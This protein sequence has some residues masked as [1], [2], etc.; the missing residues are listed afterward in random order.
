MYASMQL[1]GEKEAIEQAQVGAIQLAR[2]SVGAI[3]P[4]IDDLNVLNLPFLF[5]N[6]AHMQKVIDGPIGQRT[7]RQGDRQRQS[8]TGRPVLDGCRRAQLLRHQASDQKHRRSQGPQGSRHRQSDVRRHGQRARRQRRRHGLRSGVQR[9]A[10]RRHRRRREQSAELRLR[11]S[12]SGG[13]ILHADRAPDR[14]RN[15]RVLA[16]D[17]GHAVEGRPGAAAQARARGAGRGARAVDGL[18]EAGH[19]QGPRRRRADRRDDRQAAVPG[20]GEAGLGQ[21]C[22]ALCRHDQA[23]PG[24][25]TERGKAIEWRRRFAG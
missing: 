3:G 8:R 1:G 9:A 12:L 23:H 17:L 15:P 21:I 14:A 20:R 16:Q 7:A 25:Q 10:N 2:V 13:E 5:R 19:G 24:R 4:V 11:Q 22:A 18:R 6:T